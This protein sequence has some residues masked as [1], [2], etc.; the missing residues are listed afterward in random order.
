MQ[1]SGHGLCEPQEGKEC[2]CNRGWKTTDAASGVFCDKS[3]G[4]TSLGGNSNNPNAGKLD[5]SIIRRLL[6]YGIPGLV[7]ILMVC[8]VIYYVITYKRRQRVSIRKTVIEFPQPQLEIP[9]EARP[10]ASVMVPDESGWTNFEVLKYMYVYAHLYIH[11][12]NHIYIHI[13]INVNIHA[14][15]YVYA[16]M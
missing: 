2:L 4:S 7:G 1:C 15:A 13:Y 8:A 9:A 14:Y 5:P 11:M 3:D 16:Y 6:L 12:Y 10:D